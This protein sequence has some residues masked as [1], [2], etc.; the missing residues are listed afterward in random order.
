[1]SLRREREIE[2]ESG[3]ESNL[4]ETLEEDILW[5]FSGGETG[6]FL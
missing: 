1:M 5:F 6:S 2:G 4:H 3:G